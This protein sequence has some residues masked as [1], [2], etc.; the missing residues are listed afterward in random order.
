LDFTN[1]GPFSLF[2]IQLFHFVLI[3]VKYH[4]YPMRAVS[5]F[6]PVEMDTYQ[7]IALLYSVCLQFP[8]YVPIPLFP[9]YISLILSLQY[10][11]YT[12]QLAHSTIYL[13]S[14]PLHQLPPNTTKQ[15]KTISTKL[16]FT[17]ATLH[18]K[19]PILNTS[20]SMALISTYLN[21]KTL[22]SFK[23]PQPLLLL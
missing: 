4:T 22:H 8:E 9:C 20:I 3:F 12:K 1:L 13:Q 7:F 11:F 18:K 23:Q 5:S 15:H 14:L 16:F 2:P 10:L 19:L 6:I 21:H 17:I